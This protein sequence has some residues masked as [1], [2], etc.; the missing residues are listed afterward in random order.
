MYQTFDQDLSQKPLRWYCLG[1][2]YIVG[3]KVENYAIQYLQIVGKLIPDFNHFRATHC[4]F[5]F[6]Y[7]Q[8]S[9][10]T[11][12]AQKSHMDNQCGK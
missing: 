5:N 11:V 9:S 7:L 1:D 12:N 4:M 6:K 10:H 8:H 2:F 3:K